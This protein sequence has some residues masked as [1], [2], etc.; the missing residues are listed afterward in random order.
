MD[1]INI[2]PEDPEEDEGIENLN[3][4][5]IQ[6]DEVSSH[7]RRR[8]RKRIKVRKRIRIKKRISPKKKARKTMETIAWVVIIA[9]FVM[10]LIILVLQ[11]DLKDKRTK[12]SLGKEV[13]MTIY[14]NKMNPL[15]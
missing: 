8:K 2:K 12:K 4:D 7:G 11:L 5:E 3:S 1:K 14:M 13:S 10:T 9:A 6:E 15:A